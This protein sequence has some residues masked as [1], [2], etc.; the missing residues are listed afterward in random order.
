M[1]NQDNE[2]RKVVQELAEEEGITFNDALALAVNTLKEAT[3]RKQLF[4]CAISG[5]PVSGG[6]D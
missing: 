5:I 3:A 1:E 4:F 2:L 6:S